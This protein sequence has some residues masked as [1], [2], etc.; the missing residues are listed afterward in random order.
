MGPTYVVDASALVKAARQEAESASFSGW[1]QNALRGNA[2]LIAPPLL[3]HEVGSFLA[4]QKG[5]AADIRQGMLHNLLLGI[6][7]I[8]G[9]AEFDYA[10][11]LSFYDAAY[12]A[13]AKSTGGTLVS[14]DADL[15]A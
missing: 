8:D 3:R 1:L 7:F 9:A 5:M 6:R 15:L 14:Y 11:P 10:P 12:L 4:R 2:D 13:L